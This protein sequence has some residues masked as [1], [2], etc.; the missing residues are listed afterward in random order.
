MLWCFLVWPLLSFIS[1]T[2]TYDQFF[3]WLTTNRLANVLGLFFCGLTPVVLA[4]AKEL[5]REREV[6]HK[7]A[8]LVRASS[9]PRVPWTQ[10]MREILASRVRASGVAYCGVEFGRLMTAGEPE[11]A[12][13]V[14]LVFAATTIC[15][16]DEDI[17]EG[18]LV[19]FILLHRK[20]NVQE[21]GFEIFFECQHLIPFD[22]N[23]GRHWSYTQSDTGPKNWHLLHPDACAGQRQSPVNLDSEEALELDEADQVELKFKRN[24]AAEEPERLQAW[25]NGHTLMIAIPDSLWE[26]SLSRDTEVTHRVLQLH[27]HWGRESDFGS[28]LSL[29]GKFFPLE[30]HIVTYSTAYPDFSSA[31]ASPDGLAVIGVLFELTSDQSLSRLWQYGNILEQIWDLHGPGS[32]TEIDYFDPELLLP[33]DTKRFFR[34]YGSLTTPPCTENVKWTVLRSRNLVTEDEP[35]ITLTTS[36][37]DQKHK[38]AHRRTGAPNLLQRAES[39]KSDT[40]TASLSAC[41]LRS[42]FI[43]VNSPDL[44]FI[45]SLFA[46][47]KK[48]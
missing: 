14:S 6:K 10:K 20:L 7:N 34:Y 36:S 22:A 42:I 43:P 31:Q 9:T 30:M 17:Q 33:E 1:R 40:T 32:V 24:V 2:L 16:T 38:Q 41:E 11:M 12:I 28:E 3:L 37:W 4:V 25:N 35:I 44:N 13:P 45:E 39:T 23:E 48:H 19:V 46:L 18:Q 5:S 27:F 15:A 29:D 8:I 26:I 21:D 47:A